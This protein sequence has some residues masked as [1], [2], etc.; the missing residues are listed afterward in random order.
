[1]AAERLCLIDASSQIFRAYHA[2]PELTNSAGV[3]TNATYGFTTMLRKLLQVE[4]PTYCAAVFDPPGPTI[5]HQQFADYKKSRPETPADIKVQFPYI[6]R[7]CEA[8]GIPVL[9]VPPYEADDVIGTLATRAEAAGL[10]TTIVSEDKDLMQLVTEQVSVLSERTGRHVYDPAEVERKYGVPPERITDLLGLM[11]DSVDDI[12]GVPGIGPKRALEL[13]QTYG[14]LENAVAHAEDLAKYKYGRNLAE[15]AQQAH[16]SKRLATVYRDLEVELDLDA[17]RVQEPDAAACRELFA[18][19]GF[20]R[21]VDEFA[22]APSES[23]TTYE[24]IADAEQLQ[25]AIAAI[26]T[27]GRF[28]LEL[29]TDHGE[30]MRARIVGVALSWAQSSGAYV[31]LG[32]QGLGADNAMRVQECLQLLEPLLRGGA[33][34]IGHDLKRV[35][36]LLQ[37]H[38]IDGIEPALDTM[39]GSYV[40]HPTRQSHALDALALDVLHLRL[41]V[42]KDVLPGKKSGFETVPPPEAARY[43]AGRADAVLALS[44]TLQAELAAQPQLADLLANIEMPLMGVLAAMER[45][46]VRIDV[47][48]LNQLAERFG[49]EIDALT[50]QIF[51]T[52]GGRFNLNSPKQLGE[53]LFDKL[54]LPAGSRTATG[55]RST[56]AEILE[57]LAQEYPIARQILE[58]RELSKLKSTYLDALPQYV[59]PKSGRVHASF[60]QAVAATGRLSSSNPNLQNIPI[61]TATGRQ[62]RR[63]FIPADGCVLLTAD[64]SQIELRIMAHLSGDPA[65]AQGFREGFDIH[66]ATAAEIFGVAPEQVTHEQRD[67]AKVINFGVL[68]GMGPQRLARE[69]GI[70]PKDAR[71]F[72]DRYFGAFPQVKAYLEKTI[73]EAKERGYVCTLLGR[74]RHLPELQSGRPMTR[75]FGERIAVNTPLQGTAADLIKLAMVNL[76][77]RLGE[78]GLNAAMIIQVHDELVLEVP[79]SELEEVRTAVKE[80]MEGAIELDVPLEVQIGVGDNWMDAKG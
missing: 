70:T 50:A 17:M 49:A 80:E 29:L 56:K 79:E 38:G 48:W 69:F 71:G 72:I 59:N 3:P 78:S 24:V 7:V 28:A 66:R 74:I 63:A 32:H 33:D 45:R 57:T 46:G 35:L 42:A 20:R 64:Y 61:R 77:Q 16:L 41:T 12:P 39:L 60:D 37:R 4:K 53:I 51:E 44:P 58:Y 73:T 8:F 62:I 25:K 65:L 30:P 27:A 6:K 1:M 11:G 47:S 9:M 14:T 19:L 5:R 75:S 76:H 15:Y 22:E 18:E 26:H 34:L 36:I 68:Y 40:L 2:L 54:E 13:L 31:P 52:A 43:A 55:G 10:R 67:R 21:L 23:D